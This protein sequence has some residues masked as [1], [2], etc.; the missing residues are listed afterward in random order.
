VLLQESKQPGTTF[1]DVPCGLK[2]LFITTVKSVGGEIV[3][4]CSKSEADYYIR[5][6]FRDVLDF[7]N[8]ETWIEYPPDCS[9]EK[10][11]SIESAVLDG[12]AGIAENGAIWLDETNF[13][14]RLIPFVV[15]HLIIRLNE[16]KILADMHYAYEQIVTT[17]TG[18]GLF[19][20]GP[21]KTADIEQSLVYGAHGAKRLTILLYKET[22]IKRSYE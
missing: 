10:L 18:F 12:Q 20:S 7:E 22:D 1:Y 11:N 2:G 9:V 13:P 21:S 15:N 3:E 17:R 6:N 16:R 8:S 5:S 4:V 19:L 14:H